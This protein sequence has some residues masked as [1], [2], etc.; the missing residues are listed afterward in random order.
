[1]RSKILGDEP[2]VNLKGSIP[3]ARAG[4]YEGCFKV[5]QTWGNGQGGL[6]RME[7]LQG[8]N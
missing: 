5:R 6:V 4:V 2:I 3:E 7:A 1:M 8:G